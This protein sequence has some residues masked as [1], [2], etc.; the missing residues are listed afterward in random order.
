MH[1]YQHA[2]QHEAANTYWRGWNVTHMQLHAKATETMQV[3]PS[4]DATHAPP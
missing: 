3:I 1:G 2:D 4:A